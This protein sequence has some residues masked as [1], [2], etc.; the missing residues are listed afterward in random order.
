MSARASSSPPGK[1]ATAEWP[2]YLAARDRLESRIAPSAPVSASREAIH[3]RARCRLGRLRDVLRE[4][5]DPQTGL[6]VVH[7]TGTSG[8]GSTAVA[9]AALLHGAGLRVGLATSPYLQVATEKLQI[10]G[11]L[12]SGPDLLDAAAIVERA[13]LRWRARTGETRLTYAETWTAL[14]LHW[15]ARTRVDIAVIEVGAGGRYD[16]TNVVEPIACVVTNI[17]LDHVESLGPSLTDIAWHK[18]GIF[19]PG[20]VALTGERQVDTL[21]VI[22]NEASLAGVELRPIEPFQTPGEVGEAPHLRANR[23]LALATAAALAERGHVDPAKIDPRILDRARLPGRFEPM[24]AGDEPTVVLDGAH[25]PD[26]VAALMD[27]VGNWRTTRRL[28]PP[29]VVAGALAAKDARGLVPVL[30][31]GVALVATTATTIAKPGIPAPEIAAI[32][33]QH[34]FG[35]TVVVEPDPRDAMAAA[36]DLAAGR[37]SWVLGTGS[38]YL[39]GDLRRRWYADRAIVESRSPWPEEMAEVAE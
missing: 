26:K 6:P 32:A 5:G 37:G 1:T 31:A 17:G 22:A 21:R 15:L 34:G 23:A 36:L 13:E 30:T 12:V 19:K 20:A 25:N 8:K 9:I 10:D 38:L 35:G 11:R 24:P 14:T 28:P 39:V 29:V 7:V 3:A 4:L 18:A 33:R 2:A 27:A 16:T